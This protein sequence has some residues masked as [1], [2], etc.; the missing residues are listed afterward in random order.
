MAA[1]GPQSRLALTVCLCL[2][3][4]QR[5]IGALYRGPLPLG[6]SYGE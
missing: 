4:T 3:H 1:G 5:Q 6:F 2:S